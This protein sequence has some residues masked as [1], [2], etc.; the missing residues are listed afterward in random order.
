[1]SVSATSVPAVAP[2]GQNA[3]RLVVKP[4]QKTPVS[5]RGPIRVDVEFGYACYHNNIHQM[6][7]TSV[8]IIGYDQPGLPPGFTIAGKILSNLVVTCPLP[9]PKSPPVSPKKL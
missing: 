9:V 8:Q 7:L 1:M 6:T 4:F 5:G 2:P 3:P